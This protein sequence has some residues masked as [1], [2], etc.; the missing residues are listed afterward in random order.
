[1]VSHKTIER[2][3]DYRTLL[4]TALDKGS[5][6]IFSH[7]IADMTGGTAAQV[8]RDLMTVGYSGSPKNGYEIKD[9]LNAIEKF[10]NAPDGNKMILIGAGNLGRAILTFFAG[11]SPRF[12]ITA[13]FDADPA[14]SGRVI[15]GCPCLAREELEPFI[16]ANT[17][18]A[19]VITVP[20]TEAQKVAD[21]LVAAGVKGIVNFAPVRLRVPSKV[22]VEQMDMASALDKVAY[23]SRHQS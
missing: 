8:R 21:I 14:K 7:Q 15:C 17:V 19:A 1:M 5:P 11:L 3:I 4:K 18:H 10:M 6:A 12:T 9:L 16:R 22:F 23:F 20:A 2:L 13:A